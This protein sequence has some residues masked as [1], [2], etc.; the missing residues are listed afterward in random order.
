MTRPEQRRGLAIRRQSGQSVRLWRG[1]LEVAS[2]ARRS[3]VGCLGIR[4]ER[5][6]PLGDSVGPQ[7]RY[8]FMTDELRLSYRGSRRVQERADRINFCSTAGVPFRAVTTGGYSRT[9]YSRSAVLG[10]GSV[11]ACEYAGGS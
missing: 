9:Q 5:G 1:V 10:Y 7:W 6:R 8:V 3:D 11:H 4:A 2:V